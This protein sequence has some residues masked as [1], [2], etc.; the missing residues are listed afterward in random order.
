LDRPIA[1]WECGFS[2][3]EKRTNAVIVHFQGFGRVSFLSQFSSQFQVC[4]EVTCD[5]I[6]ALPSMDF[7]SSMTVFSTKPFA[8]YLPSLTKYGFIDNTYEVD[9]QDI[10]KKFILHFASFM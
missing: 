1:Q 10:T 2:F 7:T 6:S 9:A 5:E 8:V 3:V 4:V